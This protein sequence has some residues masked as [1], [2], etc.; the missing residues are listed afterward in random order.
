MS[1]PAR[2]HTVAGRWRL[3]VNA[4]GM[5]QVLSKQEQGLAM[6]MFYAGFGAA[7][8]AALELAEFE[9]ETAVFFLEAMRREI[10]DLKDRATLILSPKGQTP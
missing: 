7:L 3:H 8:D 6:L 10:D 5:E 9:E 4:S 2:V 1:D